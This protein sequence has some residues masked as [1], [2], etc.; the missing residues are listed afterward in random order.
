MVAFARKLRQWLG[1]RL[2]HDVPPPGPGGVP[3]TPGQIKRYD[4]PTTDASTSQ[5]GDR[6]VNSD[7]TNRN[8]RSG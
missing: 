5:E 7:S 6:A 8:H 1:D 3:W 2:D 4:T